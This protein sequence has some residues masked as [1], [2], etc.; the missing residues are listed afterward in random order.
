MLCWIEWTQLLAFLPS[1][2]ISSFFLEWNTHSLSLTESVRFTCKSVCSVL[3][4][5]WDFFHVIMMH[6]SVAG[7]E[8]LGS[9]WGL[10]FMCATLALTKILLPISTHLTWSTLRWMFSSCSIHC[11]YPSMSFAVWCFVISL[12]ADNKS[13]L[14]SEALWGQETLFW[15]CVASKTV[16]RAFSWHVRVI[17]ISILHVVSPIVKC[18]YVF[19]GVTCDLR[20]IFAVLTPFY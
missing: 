9:A 6:I 1:L 8:C 12:I 2:V 17:F 14:Q 11:D 13:S 10:T 16:N 19:H 4:K 7:W 20:E 15:I 5:K 3:L 18:T